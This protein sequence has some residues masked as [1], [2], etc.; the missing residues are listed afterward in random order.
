MDA[1]D[2]SS[3]VPL[4]AQ[5]RRILLGKIEERDWQPGQLIPSESALEQRYGLSRITVRQALGEL[6]HAGLLERHQG[7]GTFVTRPKFAHD[8]ARRPTLTDTMLEQGIV[9]GWR[10]LAAEIVPADERVGET[11]GIEPGHEVH[12]LERLRLA[13]DEAIGHHI[14]W[15]DAALAS[16]LDEAA[17]TAG[18]STHYLRA[19]PTL[20]DSL[21]ERSL[22]ALPATPQQA[23]R[24]GVEPGSPLLCI[25]RKLVTAAGG[26][27]EVM[28]A[29]YR[30]DRFTYRIT[31]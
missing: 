3:P 14:A 31:L 13:N 21:A 10:L 18:G 17:F 11:L 8:P 30:G 27:I 4:Y 25:E 28:R 19:V 5:L 1:I 9:P 12:R 7:R 26:A 24:L 2:R 16:Q 6:V 22:E 15:V 20:E 29:C 23:D